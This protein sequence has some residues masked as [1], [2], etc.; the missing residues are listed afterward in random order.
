MYK[1]RNFVNFTSSIALLPIFNVKF[2]LLIYWLPFLLNT[3]YVVL[4]TF[5]DNLLA[6]NQSDRISRLAFNILYNS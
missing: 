6:L 5:S 2:G 4:F 3:I 1:P